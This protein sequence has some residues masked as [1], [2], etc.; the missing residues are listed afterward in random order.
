ME[1]VAEK[2]DLKNGGGDCTNGGCG[3]GCGC[4]CDGCGCGCDDGCDDGGYE[5]SGVRA[6]L[7]L[8]GG[9]I[10]S[11]AVPNGCPEALP[12]T[13]ARV[14]AVTEESGSSES[15]TVVV[16]PLWVNPAAYGCYVRTFGCTHNASDGEVLKGVLQ[17]AG[18]PVLESLEGAAVVVLNTCTVKNPSQEG[19]L[20]MAHRCRRNGQFVVVAGCVPQADANMK[21]LATFS[22]IGI[23]QLD[24]VADAVTETIKGNVYRALGQ[25]RALPSLDLPKIRKNRFVEII[26]LSTGCLGACTYCKTRFARGS[27]GSYELAVILGRVEQA[28]KDGCQQIWLSSEDTGAYGLD[29]GLDISQLLFAIDALLNDLAAN[30]ICRLGM[31]NPPYILDHLDDI[32]TVLQRKHWFKFLHIPVQSGSTKVLTDMNREYT[33]EDFERCVTALR[34]RIPDI[35]IATDFICGFPGETD[36]DHQASLDLIAQYKFPVINIS[37]F[38]SRPGTAAA[39]MPKVNSAV[40]KKRSTEMTHLFQTYETYQHN[41]GQLKEVWFDG[42]SDRSDHFTGHTAE[43]V[44]V[45]VTTGVEMGKKY[46]VLIDKATKWHLEGTVVE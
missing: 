19:A 20:N 40:V 32:A 30:V 11:S 34:N 2:A 21:E 42:R 16:A 22:C 25:D 1:T 17:T 35:T 36:Q 38:Y 3:D 15:A 39:K 43:Y 23:K 27:L 29:I 5:D 31:T 45:L 7:G 24:K 33:R 12:V 41:V 13:R 9:D 18:F 37:Q 28:V 44:K 10:E 4:G 26:P 46:L 14:L 8:C 6:E